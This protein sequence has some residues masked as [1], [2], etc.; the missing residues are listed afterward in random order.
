[1]SETIGCDASWHLMHSQPS[2]LLNYFD[3]SRG[4]AGQINTLVSRFQTVQAVCQQG[5]GPVRLTELRNALAFHLVRMSRWWGFDFCPLGL[6]GVRNPHFMSYVKAHA[7]RSVEDDALLDLFTMQRHMHVGDP[8][9]ILVLGR[10]PDSSGTL[11]IFYGVDGQK[12]FRFT[13]GANGTALAWCR[14][15]YPDFASA[16]LAA[17]TYH[18]PAGTV[19]ANMREHLAAEREHAWA[20]TWHRQHFHRSGGSLLVRLYLDA[21]GQLSACQSRFGRAAFESIVNAIAFRMVRHAVERQ[22]SIAG[23]LEEGAPQQMSRRVVDV[24]RQRAR[25][26]V[27]RSIDALQ[28]PKL[29]A[30]IE[31]AA[32]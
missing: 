15:S 11:S 2:L 7:A 24:V 1:M 19:C 3:P 32:P 14:H 29:E 9:H 20:R 25:L 22:I 30:L 6:T 16:W 13:T 5:E 4:F 21:M 28:R 17:W 26:Y 23:L 18:C 31:N 27:A 8:G 10:D 12:S